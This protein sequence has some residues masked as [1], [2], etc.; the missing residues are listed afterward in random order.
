MQSRVNRGSLL[1]DRFVNRKQELHQLELRFNIHNRMMQLKG[2]AIK[3]FVDAIG[4]GKY[5][6]VN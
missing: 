5:T 1:H 6:K 4:K 3:Y 2:T